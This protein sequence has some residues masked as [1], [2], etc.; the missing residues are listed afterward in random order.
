MMRC[1]RLYDP[2]DCRFA[3]AGRLGAWYPSPSPGA[4]PECGASRQRRVPP[5]IIEWL[6]GSDRVG[7]FVWPGGDVVVAQPVRDALEKTYR[8]F[9]LKPVEMRQDPKL[10]RPGRIRKGTEPRVWLPYEGPALYELWVTAWV[11][12]DLELSTIRQVEACATCGHSAYE[13]GGVEVRKARWDA[14]KKELVPVHS[15][16]RPGEGI[17][18]HED[19]LQGADIFGVHELPGWVLCTARVRALVEDLRFT[20]VSFLEV[21]D[22]LANQ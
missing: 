15:P 17:Y 22:I 14:A 13:V 16:R 7:D 5:L 2:Q 9:E 18:V 10:K 6:P 3:Q 11:H 19:D 8:G 21:G 4:C 12:A 20:N 1:F